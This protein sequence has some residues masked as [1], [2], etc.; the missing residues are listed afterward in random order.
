AAARLAAHA[1][2]AGLKSVIF[3]PHNVEPVKLISTSIYEPVLVAV[4]GSIS[5]INSLCNEIMSRMTWGFVNI[6][7]RPYYSEGAKTLSYEIAEQFDW[8]APDH[9]VVPVASGTMLTKMRKGFTELVVTELLRSQHVKFH[10]VQASGCAPVA[11]AFAADSELIQPVEP[12]TMAKSLAIANP[13][14]GIYALRTIRETGGTATGVPDAEI[15]DGIKLLARTEGI[16]AEP[17]GG[18][19]V[20]AAARLAKEKTFRPN[21]TVV[22]VASGL[23]MKTPDVIQ[24]KIKK[25][26]TIE[27]TLEALELF[28][29]DITRAAFVPGAPEIIAQ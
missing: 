24:D 29:S 7:L 5:R 19:A 16:F 3:V 2:R 14:D 27:P 22:I 13:A 25:P 6:N 8:E 28:F 26:K 20:A 15:I 4:K 12:D 17:A 11:R 18:A 21:D 10:G 1:A 9:I 23:G